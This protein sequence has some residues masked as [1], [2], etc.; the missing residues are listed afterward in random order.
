MGRCIEAREPVLLETRLGRF[1]SLDGEQGIGMG[2]DAANAEQTKRRV[3]VAF[4][5]MPTGVD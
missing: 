1:K 5:G 2:I 3:G 4:E